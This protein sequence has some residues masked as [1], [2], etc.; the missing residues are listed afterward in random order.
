MKDH[1]ERAIEAIDAM[2]FGGLLASGALIDER[3]VAM[4]VCIDEKTVKAWDHAAL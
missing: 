4:S 1:D 3:K 2:Y